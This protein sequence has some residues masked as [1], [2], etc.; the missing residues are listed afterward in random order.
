MNN[1][2]IKNEI[3]IHEYHKRLGE[4]SMLLKKVKAELYYR[5]HRAA[6][7]AAGLRL[8]GNTILKIAEE[9]SK[10]IK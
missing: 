6:K 2:I 1:E 9:I 3:L 4:C 7:V 8:A 5:P 10:N